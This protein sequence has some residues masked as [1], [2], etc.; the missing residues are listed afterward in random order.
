MN[1]AQRS[2]VKLRRQ[3]GL[4][5]QVDAEAVANLVGLVVKPWPL[6]VQQEIQMGHFIGVAERLNPQWRRW[7]IAHAVGHRLMH[8]GNHLWIR[9]NTGFGGRFEREAED[10]A[11]ALLMDVEEAA[12]AGLREVWEV[13]EYFGVPQEMVMLQASMRIQ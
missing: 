9:D 10:F 11:R 2:A 1:R 3:L 5:G 6:Q 13:A 7:V 12:E 8:P 4:R